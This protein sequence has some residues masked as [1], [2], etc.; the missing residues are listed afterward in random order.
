[1]LVGGKVLL[2]H[3][4]SIDLSSSDITNEHNI[5]MNG[6]EIMNPKATIAAVR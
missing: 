2:N 6:V 1:M 3:K 5:N 4:A